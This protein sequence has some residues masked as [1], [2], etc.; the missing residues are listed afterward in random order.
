MNKIYLLFF[1]L[2]S[3]A[4]VPSFDAIDKGSTIWLY[5]SIISVLFIFSP[6]DTYFS[7]NKIF[8]VYSFFIL[9]VILSL[10][11]SNNIYISVVDLS[12]HLVLFTFILLML[13]NL[14]R[15]NFSFFNISLIISFFLLY[16][17]IFSLRPLFYFINNHGFNFSIISSL[18]VDALKGL[19]GNRN[20]TT[21]SIV[22]KIPFL[23]YLIYSSKFRFK[24][25]YSIIFFLPLLALFLI[26]SRAALLSLIFIILSSLLS[27]LFFHNKKLSIVFVLI[28]LISALYFSTLL[29]PDSSSNTSSKLAT[30][31]F[32]NESSS[33]RFFLWE[34]AFDYISSN[35]FIGCGIGNW[36]VESA[37][38]WNSFGNQYL[39]PYHAHNDFLEFST[40]LG[41]LGGL[42]YF[43]LFLLLF[44]SAFANYFKTKDFKFLV[45]FLSFSAL[46]VDSLLNFP[47]ERPFIQVIFIVLLSLI[48]HYDHIQKT[49]KH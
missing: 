22:I 40:E 47:F 30:I 45:L 27:I 16:E 35:P 38:Y 28:P 13:S 9:Q 23:I 18:D 39:V 44:S 31:D 17:S 42:T 1:L 36:K 6:L 21:A 12:R 29:I 34:N 11:Y 43:L 33:Y 15:F 5:L 48:I 2:F 10:A 32:S 7:K 49:K 37:V 26:N 25:F 19:L 24:F 8:L 41:V 46:F 20:I 3:I 4:F 14:K